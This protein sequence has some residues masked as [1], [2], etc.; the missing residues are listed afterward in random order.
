MR[1]DWVFFPMPAQRGVPYLGSVAAQRR[2]RHRDTKEG[3]E[4]GEDV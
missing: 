3:D 2:A 4:R 1:R